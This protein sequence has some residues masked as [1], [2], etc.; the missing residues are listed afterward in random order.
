M[1]DTLHPLDIRCDAPPFPVIGACQRLGFR[2]PLDDRWYRLSQ[3]LAARSSR[4]STP[5]GAQGFDSKR[6]QETTC[7]CGESLP[8]LEKYAITFVLEKVADYLLGQCP[9]CGTMFW[10]EG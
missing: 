5:P 8:N 3:F 10:E 6:T 1:S 2:S 9:R 4:P 7:T